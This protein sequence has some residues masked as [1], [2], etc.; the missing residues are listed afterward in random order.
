[1]P[2]MRIALIALIALSRLTWAD[3]PSNACRELAGF[4]QKDGIEQE[5]STNPSAIQ[6]CMDALAAHPDEANL[7]AY[8]GRALYFAGHYPE[9]RKAIEQ[10]AN[11]GSPVGMGL[12][13]VLYEYGFGVGKDMAQA[14]AWYRKG[15]EKG[16]ALAQW[17]LANCYLNGLGVSANA[18]EALAWLR[19]AADQGDAASMFTLGELYREGRGVAKDL[20]QAKDWN[21]KAA[22]LGHSGASARRLFNAI[23]DFAPKPDPVTPSRQAPVMSGAPAS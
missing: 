3:D 22:E 9:S 4:N 19:K 12:M 17:N 8:L 1:M 14:A 10:S 21:D 18:P 11:L 5:P 6:A 16:N 2:L 20:A 23:Q 15:A 7:W 13:G